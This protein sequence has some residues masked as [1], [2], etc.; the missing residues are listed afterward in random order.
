MRDRVVARLRARQLDRALAAGVSPE[1]AAALAARAQWL[2]GLWCRR[3]MASSLHQIV[4]NAGLAGSPSWVR[5]NPHRDRVIAAALAL[6][7]LAD[8]LLEPPRLPLEGLHRHGF[9]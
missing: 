5:V 6:S 3:A 1:S 7:E 8:H 9:C 4:R 2:C